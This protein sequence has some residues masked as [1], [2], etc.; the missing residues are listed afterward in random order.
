MFFE[1]NGKRPPLSDEIELLRSSEE[2]SSKK[3]EGADGELEDLRFL[4]DL[5]YQ[6]TNGNPAQRPTSQGLYDMLLSKTT[7]PPS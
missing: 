3:F 6:C 2:A 1:Q 4:V 5:F 7:V